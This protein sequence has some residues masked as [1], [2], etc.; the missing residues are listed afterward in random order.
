MR[1]DLEITRQNIDFCFIPNNSNILNQLAP[2]FYLNID[3]N[4]KIPSDYVSCDNYN[5]NTNF[6]SMGEYELK[7][8]P[9]IDN[10]KYSKFLLTNISK[11]STVK[12]TKVPIYFY[13]KIPAIIKSEA[14]VI[15]D[16]FGKEVSKDEYLV[17]YNNDNTLVYMNK[18]GQT[19]FIRYTSEKRTK[20]ELLNLI[21]VFQEASWSDIDS[22][23]KIAE[24]K[25]IYI[26]NNRAILTSYNGELYITYTNETGLIRP[27]LGNI[28]D[29]WFIGILNNEYKK[30][31]YTY[32][33]PEYYLQQIDSD[34]RYKFIEFKKCTK[35]YGKYVKSQYNIHN[36]KSE[37]IY[38]Y[39]KDGN[40]GLIKY[41][42]T[43]N[44]SKV[45]LAYDNN[46]SYGE[47]KSYNSD[48]VLESPIEIED[49][50]EVYASHYTKEDYYEYN[51][52]D[53]RTITQD[54]LTF[55]AIY[56]KPNITEGR[57]VYHAIIG[58]IKDNNQDGL[59]FNSFEEYTTYINDPSR[60]YYHL[61]LFNLVF[62]IEDLTTLD[63]R[64]LKD[65]ILEK[66]EIAKLSIDML[67][68]DIINNNI[69]IPTRDAVVVSMNVKRLQDEGKISIDEN[70]EL[71][72]ESKNYIR[73][74]EKNIS[75]TLH[76]STKPLYEIIR[77]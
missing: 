48:G 21:P 22:T 8:G 11:F 55:Y 29:S 65:V 76:A 9:Y 68:Y 73:E 19:L 42:F 75:R 54:S 6:K 30:D 32:N 1:F 33:M 74:L 37:D 5:S 46:I 3:S 71:T 41:A 52:L 44:K 67:Y 17:D 36:T 26:Y 31:S 20:K 47:L 43:Y 12:N 57:S 39:I 63:M 53:L 28:E 66:E 4:N 2:V 34:G 58:D 16:F 77:K 51:L 10:V 24:F 7:E 14:I 23:G 64:D 25:Y 59:Y 50:D 69:T 72:A 60:N 49:K 18:T 45:G 56:I 62:N 15:E 70:D 40:T 35:L 13:H 61:G 38:L 27:P